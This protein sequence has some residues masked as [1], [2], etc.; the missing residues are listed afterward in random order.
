M[1]D[2]AVIGAGVI[3]AA[4][5]REL[6][7]FDIRAVIL[8]KENDVS[9]G[10]SKA[11][12][13][14]VHAGYDPEENTLMARLNARGNR[15]YES[16][17]AGLGV[18][19]SRNGSLVV[20]FDEGQME[21]V[22]RLRRR[23]INNGVPGLRILARDE[24]L[25]REPNVN[26]AAHG[27]LY[28]E[29]AGIVDPMMLVAA[30]VSDAVENGAK[31]RFGFEVESIESVNGAYEIRSKDRTVRAGCVINAAGVHSD[32]IHEMAAPSAFRIMPRRGQ[33]YL[34]DKSE[35][36][37]V[38]ST[39]FPCPE[40]NGKGILVAPTTHG[41]VMVGPASDKLLERDDVGTTEESLDNAIK[42]ARLLVPSISARNAIRT[43]AGVRAEPDTG[44][45]VIGEAEGAKG[46]F[47]AAG[48]KS[49]GLT[50]APAIAEMVIEMLID[51]GI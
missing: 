28:A 48:I 20:A 8:E 6:S 50:A 19:F 29:T 44:D 34:L 22:E 5:I 39:I 16:L 21:H 27:A 41:N 51:G 26:P 14:I 17:C 38:G 10:A 12:S 36:G 9:T 32:K 43:F 7:R 11:N 25:S 49:P 3:G 40:K 24:L 2:V 45:F 18:P 35:S 4:I 30:L 31:Y 13:G 15:M 46:F 23:G 42:G 33:Y 1:Y 37:I 47:D